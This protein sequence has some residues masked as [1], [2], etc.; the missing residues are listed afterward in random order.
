M[1]RMRDKCPDSLDSPSAPV[2]ERKG[3]GFLRFA[4]LA[5]EK[6]RNLIGCEY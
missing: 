6:W 2:W 3:F 4:Q 1:V 5:V